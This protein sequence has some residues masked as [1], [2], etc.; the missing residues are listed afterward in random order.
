MADIKPNHPTREEMDRWQLDHQQLDPW[1]AWAIV[2]R[3]IALVELQA[4]YIVNPWTVD[5]TSQ[6]AFRI[7]EHARSLL[8]PEDTK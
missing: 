7:V 3:L 8:P 6:E 2:R 5:A 1:K 4:R